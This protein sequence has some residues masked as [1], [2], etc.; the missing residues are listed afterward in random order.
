MATMLLVKIGDRMEVDSRSVECVHRRP[1]ADD[2]SLAGATDP[3]TMQVP[4]QHA[5]PRQPT[6]GSGWWERRE[7][8]PRARLSRLGSKRKPS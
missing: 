5:P 7:I 4:A 8:A 6:V 3:F 2:P 1:I